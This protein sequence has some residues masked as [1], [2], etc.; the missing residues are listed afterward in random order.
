[1][2]I[3]SV[4]IAVLTMIAMLTLVFALL[5]IP[6]AVFYFGIGLLLEA[7]PL[8]FLQWYGVF[9]CVFIAVRLLK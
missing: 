8:S 5:L 9:L 7:S 1:M 6:T 3:S 2:R 4:F